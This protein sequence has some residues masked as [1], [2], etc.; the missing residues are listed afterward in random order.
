MKTMV[1][2]GVLFAALLLLTGVVFAQGDCECYE[3]FFTN[4]DNPFL[5]TATEEICLDYENHTGT[6]A[7]CDLSLFS[8]SITQGLIYDPTCCPTYFKFHGNDNNVIT[9]EQACPERYRAWGHITDY[10]NCMHK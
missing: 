4:L 7:G 10:E 2:L 3:I 5:L 9:A 1:K 8:G 6:W